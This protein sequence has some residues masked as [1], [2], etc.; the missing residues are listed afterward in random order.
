MFSKKLI[1]GTDMLAFFEPEKSHIDLLER[2]DLSMQEYENICHR[3]LEKI[4]GIK[5]T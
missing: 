4:I 5:L 3:N 2:F 1:F